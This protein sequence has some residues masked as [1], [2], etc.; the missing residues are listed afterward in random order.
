MGKSFQVPSSMLVSFRGRLLKL[1]N[2]IHPVQKSRYAGN[3]TFCTPSGKSSEHMLSNSLFSLL[4]GGFN[5]S[6]KYRSNWIFSPGTG[7]NWNHHLVSFEKFMK[8]TFAVPKNEPGSLHMYIPSPLVASN[9]LQ[10]RQKNEL[11]HPYHEENPS[12]G[13]TYFLS[14]IQYTSILVSLSGDK[15]YTLKS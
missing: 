15:L 13:R 3:S 1:E 4:V 8:Y 6:E 2:I 7:K 14:N 10:W 12:L 9:S 11:Q 5:P